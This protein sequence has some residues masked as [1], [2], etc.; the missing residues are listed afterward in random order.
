MHGDHD[1]GAPG[2]QAAPRSFSLL[3]WAATV[4]LWPTPHH[5]LPALQGEAVGQFLPSADLFFFPF[6]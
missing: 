6:H 1:M 4:G 3:G 2:E 5:M